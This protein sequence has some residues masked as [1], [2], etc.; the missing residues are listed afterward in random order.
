MDEF[1]YFNGINGDRGEYDLPPMTG[2]ELLGFI[3]GEAEAENMDEL[4]FRYQQATQ[5]HLGVKEGVDPKSLAQSGWGVIFAHDADPAIKE[6]L[7][8]LLAH[9]QQEAG[10]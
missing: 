5:Q 8:E 7:S 9:R 10:Q 2:E 4:R 1:L 6:A 3:T